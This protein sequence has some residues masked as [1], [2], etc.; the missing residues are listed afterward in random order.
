MMQLGTYRP[1]FDVSIEVLAR[2]LT[3]IEANLDEWEA[4]SK[5]QGYTHRQMVIEFTNKSGATNLMKNP[6]YMND[7]QLKESAMKYFKELGFTP[8]ALNK[9]GNPSGEVNDPLEQFLNEVS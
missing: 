8:N 7:L 2:T 5:E 4:Q 3:D 9:L 1:Q 6:Y